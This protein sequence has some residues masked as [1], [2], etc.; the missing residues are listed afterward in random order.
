VTL[1]GHVGAVHAVDFDAADGNIVYSGGWDHSI[2][3]WDIEQQVNT[4][5]KVR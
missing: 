5:T 3:S 4:T 1:N 2:R